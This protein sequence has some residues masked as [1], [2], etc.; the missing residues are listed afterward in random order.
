MTQLS[1]AG[2]PAQMAGGHLLWP[3]VCGDSLIACSTA[4]GGRWV[5]IKINISPSMSLGLR[6]LPEVVHVHVCASGDA[7][8]L[9]IYSKVYYYRQ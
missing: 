7:Q 6:N 3:D 4:T 8:V 9:I 5:K 1:I 2:D